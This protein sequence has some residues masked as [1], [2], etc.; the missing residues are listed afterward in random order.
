MK[1]RNAAAAVLW[2]AASA[3]FVSATF[4]ADGGDRANF[5]WVAYSGRDPAVQSLAASPAQYRNPIIPGF[6]PDPSILRVAGDYY[7]VNSSFA[8][9]PGLTVYHSRDLVNWQQL[10]SAI[11]RPRQFDFSGLGIARAIFAPTL[12][13]HAGTFYIV[14][15]CVDCGST[16]LL[17]TANPAGPWSDPAW[18][19]PVDGVDPDL[20]IDRDGKAWVANNGPPPGTPL[21]EGHRAIWLQQI[22]LKLKEMQGPRLLLVNGGVDINRRPI[23]IEGPHLLSKDGWYYLICAE[24]GT[25]DGHSEVVFRSRRVTGPYIPGPHN[26]ILTQRDLDPSRSLPIAAA[27]HADFVQTS[28]GHWWAVFLAT[29]PYAANLSN[30]GRETFLLPVSWRGGWP[31]ILPPQTP[32]PQ[33]LA[34]PPLPP[35]SAVDRSR[36]RDS[37]NSQQLAADWEMIRTPHDTWYELGP[38]TG[39]TIQA[40]AVS[41][42]GSA[43]PSFLGKRQRHAD[44]SVETEMRYAPARGGDRAGLIAFADE[45]HHFFLGLGQTAAGS[46]LLV[47]ERN[48]ADDPDDGRII[49]AA[50]YPSPPGQ[51][52]RLKIAVRGPAV[53]FWYAIADGDW[54]LLLGNADGRILASELS[55]QFTGVLLGVYAARTGLPSGAVL[56]P[57][58]GAPK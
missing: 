28:N 13:R 24:G 12:R 57:S 45:R 31:Q 41:I 36:W 46:Q 6:Q 37:F 1:L 30:L 14:G 16:F 5:S 10:G 39:L 53:D 26:P 23:W 2:S 52:L 51:P 25:A 50:P 48:G 33:V 27:G 40:R 34:R 17:S 58:P 7:L 29:R 11:D 20:F 44:A 19:K 15:T 54:Q 21:Y 49:A 35:G 56:R 22:D 38:H 43:N 8:F 9:F 4:A 42:S 47:A 32:V 55:N 18:L 3:G